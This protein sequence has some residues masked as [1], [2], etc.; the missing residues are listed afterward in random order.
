[1]YDA[2]DI[3]DL[4]NR[5]K[6][7]KRLIKFTVFILVAGIIAALAF[8]FDIWYPKLRGIGKQYKTIVNSGKLADG[9]F[10]IEVSGGNDYQLRYT[11]K[12]IIVQNDTYLYFYDTDGT[13]LK[14]RQHS[15]SN[16]VLRVANGRALVY[17]NGGNN[18]RLK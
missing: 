17:E 11:V 7:K 18:S 10:P 15:Y 3:V 14:R 2:D 5:K 16:S 1:M 12:K 13:L 8:T 9:N 6:R 4:K